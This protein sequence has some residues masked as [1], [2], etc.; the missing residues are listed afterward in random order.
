MPNS[1]GKIVGNINPPNEFGVYRVN[2]EVNGVLKKVKVTFFPKKWTPQQVIDAIN[3]A[4]A[5]KEVHK[6]NKYRGNT[7]A[8]MRIEMV[9]RNGKIISAYPLY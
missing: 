3:E 8:G 6:N 7:D 9:I 2:I 5:N 4:F 1:N